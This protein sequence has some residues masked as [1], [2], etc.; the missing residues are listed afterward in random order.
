MG[1]VEEKLEEV[2]GGA[3][4]AAASVLHVAALSAAGEVLRIQH[5]TPRSEFDFFLLNASRARSDA[6]LTTGRILRE[7]PELQHEIQGAPDDVEALLDWRKRDLRKDEPPFLIV[8]S[9]G[10]DIDPHHPA[11]AASTRAVLYTAEA[12][13]AT[14]RRALPG[15]VKVFGDPTPSLRRALAFTRKELGAQAVSIEAGPSTALSLY[16]DPL[17]IDE[18]WLSEYLEEELADGLRGPRFLASS[19]LD[20]LLPT[21]S[22]MEHAQASGR[23]RFT[24]RSRTS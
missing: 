10:R 8:L 5:D 11:F 24:R 13:V 7:E 16:D 21:R 3:A 14:L 1:S 17:Q 18:L 6:I 15:E 4:P 9:S 19:A 20:S 23:W 12:R 2:L 22:R